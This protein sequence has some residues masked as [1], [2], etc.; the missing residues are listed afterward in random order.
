VTILLFCRNEGAQIHSD[1]CCW[2]FSH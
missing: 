1:S 2:P